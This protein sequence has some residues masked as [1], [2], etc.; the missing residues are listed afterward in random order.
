MVSPDRASVAALAT[1]RAVRR[2]L[3]PPMPALH[4]RKIRRGHFFVMS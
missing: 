1:R 3:S 4:A 2:I